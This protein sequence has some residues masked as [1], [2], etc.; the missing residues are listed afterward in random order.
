MYAEA[1]TTLIRHYSEV[2]VYS[3]E[4]LILSTDSV[5][6]VSPHMS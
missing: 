2:T 6:Y 3:R 4:V 5:V 1:N